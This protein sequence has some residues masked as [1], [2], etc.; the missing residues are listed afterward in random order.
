[1]TQFNGLDHSYFPGVMDS[2]Q[3]AAG[4]SAL[5]K[6][7]AT[8]KEY[9][10]DKQDMRIKRAMAKHVALVPVGETGEH[11]L[12]VRGQVPAFMANERCIPLPTKHGLYKL[13]SSSLD[14][15]K[16]TRV[17]DICTP[18]HDIAF[19]PFTAL[20]MVCIYLLRWDFPLLPKC[21]TLV[22]GPKVVVPMS[23]TA[24]PSRVKRIVYLGYSSLS[25]EARGLVAF[26]A[27][28]KLNEA[29]FVHQVI[30]GNEVNTAMNVVLGLMSIILQ[31]VVIGTAVLV[32]VHKMDFVK[33]RGAVMKAYRL[34]SSNSKA[35]A[36]IKISHVTRAEYDKVAKGYAKG[37]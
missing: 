14:L 19:P 16:S 32:D 6:M 30:E 8:S 17:L 5:L 2:I 29:V 10:S 23:I 3:D 33:E 25:R 36:A 26:T 18:R 9:R 11:E 13:D 20:N 21:H 15:I 31:G 4:V 7:R 22:I 12:V 37:W 1:M 27:P 35:L 28:G 24:S 34:D